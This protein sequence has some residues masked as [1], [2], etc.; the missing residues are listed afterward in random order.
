MHLPTPSQ[1]TKNSS[2]IK[3]FALITSGSSPIS[4]TASA[5]SRWNEHDISMCYA[6]QQNQH[7][8]WRL[9]TVELAKV[10]GQLALACLY[11][12]GQ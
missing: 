5:E 1:L 12:F 10:I 11:L 2:L 7:P 3:Y 8:T 4:H 9:V 6:T